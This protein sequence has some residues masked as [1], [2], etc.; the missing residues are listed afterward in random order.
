M[1][2]SQKIL[3]LD[4]IFKEIRLQQDRIWK[5]SLILVESKCFIESRE[6]VVSPEG[7]KHVFIPHYRPG[8]NEDPTQYFTSLFSIKLGGVSEDEALEFLLSDL[9]SLGF[10]R[11]TNFTFRYDYSLRITEISDD[12]LIDSNIFL[13]L[14]IDETIIKDEIETKERHNLQISFIVRRMDVSDIYQESEV[15][16]RVINKFYSEVREYFTERILLVLSS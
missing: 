4:R 14:N 10:K 8:E 1:H 9:D 7:E 2:L 11:C 6:I 16:N 15:R 13:L 12:N 3:D 5:E